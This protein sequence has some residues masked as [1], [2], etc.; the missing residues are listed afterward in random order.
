MRKQLLDYR[1]RSGHVFFRTRLLAL[2]WKHLRDII[3]RKVAARL[4]R[5]HFA[6]GVVRPLNANLVPHLK[7]QS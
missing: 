1:S 6:S 5:L 4:K 3:L 2:V 7:D